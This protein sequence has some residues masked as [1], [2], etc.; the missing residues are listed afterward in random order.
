MSVDR[1][2]VHT[3]TVEPYLGAGGHGP[4]FGPVVTVACYVRDQIRLV[5][6][7]TGDEAVSR[8]TVYYPAGTVVPAG[9]R[10]VANGR[11]SHVLTVS[12]HDSGGLTTL[13]HVEVALA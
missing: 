12:R 2:L 10:V 8:T 9:S 4:Q 3:S 7:S 5:R 13:D 11:E 1:F 6:T